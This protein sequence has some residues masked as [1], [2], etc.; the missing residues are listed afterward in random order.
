MTRLKDKVAIIT[1]AGS[2]MGEAS[3]RRFVD[4]G[5]RVVLA[6]VDDNTQEIAD[7]LG[8][9]ALFLKLDVSDEENW[10][11]VV[12]ETEEHFG[13]INILVN[14]AGVLG[15]REDIQNYPADAFKETVDINQVG[16]LLGMK[17]VYPSMTQTENGSIINLSSANGIVGG[18]GQ[19][20]YDSTK[21]AIRGM[22]KTAAQEFSPEGIRVNSVHP[23]TIAT[24]IDSEENQEAMA[25]NFPMRRVGKPEEVANMI[26][27]LASDESS[28]STGAEFVVDGGW[29][30]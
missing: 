4:E 1:G 24:G 27:Y 10:Q 14:N 29:T 20:A 25:E 30:S 13:P 7:E 2:G 19:I 23:G 17:T 15:P 18:A 9:N 21:F 8:N 6:D 11:E 3:A 28:Y 12:K 26:T 22:T 5:A 16:V